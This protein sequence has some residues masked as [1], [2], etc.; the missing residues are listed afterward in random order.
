MSSNSLFS[1][2]HDLFTRFDDLVARFKMNKIE[3]VG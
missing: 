2:L 1:F 3:T